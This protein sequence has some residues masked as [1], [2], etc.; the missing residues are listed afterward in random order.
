MSVFK[1]EVICCYKTKEIGLRPKHFNKHRK[2]NIPVAICKAMCLLC[3]KTVG[4]CK[5]YNNELYYE[6]PYAG[7]CDIFT[8]N[9]ELTICAH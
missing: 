8:E 7:I 1:T 4:V 9:I 6:T 3:Q 2:R 5:A